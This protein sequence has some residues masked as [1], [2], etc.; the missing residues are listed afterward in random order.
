MAHS[1]RCG[2][3]RNLLH[4]DRPRTE[5]LYNPDIAIL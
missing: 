1:Q 5:F 4:S 3:I 2:A